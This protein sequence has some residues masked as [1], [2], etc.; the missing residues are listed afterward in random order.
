MARNFSCSIIT[1]DDQLFAAAEGLQVHVLGAGLQ[2]R[3]MRELH[4]DLREGDAYLHND[5]ILGNTHPAD[6]TILVPVFF[7][8][9]HVFT[10]AA[11]AHQADCGN[12][13]PST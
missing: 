5:P 7:E 1:A 10:A 11:K 6:H 2:T 4:P 9:R 13:E 3:S 8:G 12:A